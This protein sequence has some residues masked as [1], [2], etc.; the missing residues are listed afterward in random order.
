MNNLDQR[1]AALT[2]ALSKLSKPVLIALM[3][4]ISRKTVP[5]N[6]R[7]KDAAWHAACVASYIASGMQDGNRLRAVRHL[8]GIDR[9]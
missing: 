7:R 8:L 2:K 6:Y 4:G 9:F 5:S 1:R 3:E